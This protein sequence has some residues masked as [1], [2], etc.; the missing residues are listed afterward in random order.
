MSGYAG[1]DDESLHAIILSENGIHACQQALVGV[2]LT[3][4]LECGDEIDPR[5]VEFARK[6]NIKCEYCIDCQTEIDKLPK[7]KVKMLDWVL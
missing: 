3:H 1:P 2:I 7:A 4:C 6:H 5:R